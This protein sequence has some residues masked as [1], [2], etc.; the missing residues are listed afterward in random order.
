MHEVSLGMLLLLAGGCRSPSPSPSP[1]VSP[2]TAGRAPAGPRTVVYA[3][4]R[5]EPLAGAR[6]DAIGVAFYA[7][8]VSLG[9]GDM[10]WRARREPLSLPAGAHAIAVV[11]VE[12]A[13]APE[14]RPLDAALRAY[15]VEQMAAVARRPEVRELQL[16]YEAPLSERPFLRA[17]VAELRAALGP[18]ARLSM[19]AL[20]SWCL[21]DGWVTD[22]PVDEVVPMVYRLGRD[23]TEVRAWLDGGR[24]FRVPLC[25]HSVAVSLD[26]PPPRLQP[27]RRRFVFS[28]RSWSAAALAAL[29]SGDLQGD[30]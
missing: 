17:L 3:W 22:L 20:A 14:R 30:R 13:P 24:D 11:H 5:P 21:G 2:S 4:N 6:V 26:D 7:A 15:L 18:E 27:G 25:R 23:R 28:A 19:T 9:K 10:V 16:D 29:T 8:T 1:S 12:P